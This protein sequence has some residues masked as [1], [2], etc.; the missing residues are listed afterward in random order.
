MGCR[1]YRARLRQE[2]APAS[3]AVVP[4]IGPSL[5]AAGAGDWLASQLPATVG[6]GNPNTQ[7]GHVGEIAANAAAFFIPGG[8][9]VDAGRL[10]DGIAAK[11]AGMLGRDAPDAGAAV[12]AAGRAYPS[13]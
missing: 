4:V 2:R 7:M 1:Q 13:V 6:G 12:N 10:G 5:E 9:E 11:I 3:A 8:G